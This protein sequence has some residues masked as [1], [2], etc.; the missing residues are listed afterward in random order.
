MKNRFIFIFFISNLLFSCM[1]SVEED[2]SVERSL[3]DIVQIDYEHHISKYGRKFLLAT[4]KRSESYELDRKVEC[5]GIAASIYNSKEELITTIKSE[6]GTIDNKS[7]KFIFKDDV[8]LVQIDKEVTMYSD[9][10]ILNYLDNKMECNKPVKII[11]ANGSTL[12][13]DSM[14]SDFDKGD[15][16]FTNLDIIY[17]YEEDENEGEDD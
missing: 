15:I 14:E 2:L 16:V 6:I 1:V 12:K 3:P 17:Y 10:V 13:A 8:V 7:N 5:T 9:E 4:I 11:K